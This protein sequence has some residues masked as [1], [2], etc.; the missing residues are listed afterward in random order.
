M[1]KECMKNTAFFLIVLAFLAG[2][3][4]G[5]GSGDSSVTLAWDA[6]LNNV[7][8]SPLIDLAGYKAY[9]GLTPGDYAEVGNIVGNTTTYTVR[10]LQSG[11]SYYFAVKA[12]DLSGNHSDFSVPL[13]VDIP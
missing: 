12:Y 2:C 11:R 8:G 6:P 13:P 5:G 4:G 7:D 10:N 1:R 9:V 3:G